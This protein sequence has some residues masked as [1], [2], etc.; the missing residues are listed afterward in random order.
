MKVAVL[1]LA[2]VALAACETLQTPG[3]RDGP[4]PSDTCVLLSVASKNGA[5]DTILGQAMQAR[6]HDIQT[7][8]LQRPAY[9]CGDVSY[10]TDPNQLGMTFLEAGFS[11]D[12]HYAALKLQTVAGPLAGE[13]YT[14]LYEAEDESWTLRGCRMDWIS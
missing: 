11:A 9:Q 8:A 13:G 1:A 5:T 10:Q 12:R 3:P 4:H 6:L 14:C 7:A 2:C